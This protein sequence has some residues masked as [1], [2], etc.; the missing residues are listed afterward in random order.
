M[1]DGYALPFGNDEFDF[2]FMHD[3]C[4]HIINFDE[5]FRE[6]RRVLNPINS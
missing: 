4:E 3:V 2:V 1:V 6:Y 5:C